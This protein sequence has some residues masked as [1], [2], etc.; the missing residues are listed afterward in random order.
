MCC[1]RKSQLKCHESWSAGA[2]SGS[3]D[4]TLCSSLSPQALF[5]LVLL[6]S[7]AGLWRIGFPG[8]LLVR[9]VVTSTCRNVRQYSHPPT[10]D[11][12]QGKGHIHHA[13]VCQCLLSYMQPFVNL[14]RKY[15]SLCCLGFVFVSMQGCGVHTYTISIG[16]LLLY[17][18]Y[19]YIYMTCL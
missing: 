16:L 14:H 10:A 4:C 2:F 12:S 17:Y 19:I 6:Q 3:L 9:T 15:C 13:D 5:D 8:W 11:R 1:L 7:S 18:I